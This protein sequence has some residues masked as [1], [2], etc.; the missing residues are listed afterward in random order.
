MKSIHKVL[1]SLLVSIV[2]F[3]VFTI[4]GFSGLFEQ[5]ETD[6]Y[7]E[8]VKENS[9]SNLDGIS[10]QLNTNFAGL[11]A[12]LQALFSD[13]AFK[14][15]YRVNQS[16]ADIIR[17]QE[18]YTDLSTSNSGLTAIRIVNAE[19]NELHYSTRISDVRSQTGQQINYRSL[20]TLESAIPFEELLK[21]EVDSPSIIFSPSDNQF[22]YSQVIRDDFDLF[23][24]TAIAYISPIALE[25]DLIQ[26]GQ[27]TS[28][29]KIAVLGN[30]LLLVN[31]PGSLFSVFQ[32]ELLESSEMLA[33]EQEFPIFLGDIGY[34]FF[35]LVTDSILVENLKLFYLVPLSSVELSTEFRII[36]LT[37]IF[38]TSF[39]ILFLLLNI[40]QDKMILV[41]DRLKRFQIYLVQEYFDKK[42]NID[43]KN[44]TNELKHR[45]NEVRKQITSGLKNLDDKQEAEINSLID[46]NWDDLVQA[47]GTNQLPA[48]SANLDV[49]K[50]EKTLERIVSNL[51]IDASQITTQSPTA[52]SGP[53][54]PAK[55][56]TPISTDGSFDT[57][58][59]TP[60]EVEEVGELDE[61]ET[62]DTSEMTPVEVDEV[63]EETSEVVDL[64][65]V[66]ELD[67]VEE[68]ESLDTS[69]MTPVEVEEVGELDEVE[70][71]DTSEMTPVEVEEVSELD[72]VEE[73]ESLNTSE[74]TPVEVDEV[75]ELDEVETLDTSEMT[76]VEVDE[77]SEETSEVVD[78]SEVSELDE[79]EE[80]ES[81]DTS[82]MTPVEVD[83][84]SEETSEVVDLSEVSELDE[85]EEA[86]SLDTSEMT[87]VEVEEVSELD[88]LE[89]ADETA[90]AV[91][92]IE[93]L[94]TLDTSEMTP[95]EVD[96]VSE[97]TSEVVDLSEV[98]E[99]TSE[100]VDLSEVSELDEVEEAESLDT[101]EMTPVEV[102]E[103]SELDELEE[104]DETA[105]AVSEGEALSTLDTSEMTPIDVE[106][107]EELDEVEPLAASSDG[108]LSPYEEYELLGKLDEGSV[109]EFVESLAEVEVENEKEHDTTSAFM[110]TPVPEILQD[111]ESI[112]EVKSLEANE[113][114]EETEDISE[115]EEVQEAELVA[116]LEEVP[117]TEL[118]AELEEVDAADME[119]AAAEGESLP[120]A[121]VEAAEGAALSNLSEIENEEDIPEAEEV[122]D[123]ELESLEALDDADDESIPEVEILNEDDVLAELSELE[124]D[125]SASIQPAKSPGTIEEEA[126]IEIGFNEVQDAK[127][128]ESEGIKS[129]LEENDLPVDVLLPSEKDVDLVKIEKPKRVSSSSNLQIQARTEGPSKSD[130]LT[131]LQ[132]AKAVIPSSSHFS[133][134]NY[135]LG[136][137]SNYGGELVGARED[138][139]EN[140]EIFP[141]AEIFN[142]FSRQNQTISEVDGIA[143][144][145]DSAYTTASEKKKSDSKLEQLIDDVTN[146]ESDESV[147]SIDELIGGEV[148]DLELQ[149]QQESENKIEG[150]ILE[151]G[152]VKLPIVDA[153]VDFISFKK[154]F[155]KGFRG[156]IKALMVLSR[157]LKSRFAVLMKK[158]KGSLYFDLNIGFDGTIDHNCHLKLGDQIQEKHLKNPHSIVINKKAGYDNF[159]DSVPKEMSSYNT[160]VIIPMVNDSHSHVLLG[161]DK[162]L[163]SI[164]DLLK[165]FHS[166]STSKEKELV[167]K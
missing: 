85:L 52:K 148:L 54:I 124:Q 132:E 91:S 80:A 145:E 62:L 24:G 21:E 158:E 61:V 146:V 1:I 35:P 141:F 8:R 23:Q 32:Q 152:D 147:T 128:I 25:L 31:T 66:S 120:E 79:V 26:Q 83:E 144:I 2:I 55:P 64:S 3:T 139:W 92:E 125:N 74:M 108:K 89:E 105:E 107:V 140:L 90:E 29:E 14:R 40:R 28:S 131:E 115:L 71:L 109:P 117:E 19:G 137:V 56:S 143:Q 167:Q 20:E 41:S 157:M 110:K 33:S 159:I 113:E 22:I 153:G 78:L 142:S 6:F 68:A 138:E 7:F 46:R 104:A 165:P 30:D 4:L 11:S 103:V 65:E 59:M 150:F 99:E 84:V 36:I 18:L 151:E 94:S 136:K 76:P 34:L 156:Q 45:K 100:V 160:L 44:W 88:E 77:V 63:S 134:Y 122:T 10:D 126:E 69:E 38:L 129:L 49:Q 106:E 111:E 67:E 12:D 86:E 127:Q 42:E 114:L 9:Y 58:K 164:H 87:P 155:R 119:T 17:R 95:V 53:A 15:S 102:E 112:G 60:V 57:S 70:T 162:K 81:L 161:F 82:E 37:A 73:A 121:F 47:L 48:G 166:S 75:G 39:L 16:Q 72:E 135:D 133:L 13:D 98:S 101:S 123:F 154:Q 93:A 50:L 51:T 27:L 96:E 5:I 97:E 118:L 149:Y 116:D 130:D 163:T 43:I